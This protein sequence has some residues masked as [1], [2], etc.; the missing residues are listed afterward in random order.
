MRSLSLGTRLALIILAGTLITVGSVLLIAYRELVDDFE[1]LLTEQQQQETRR[2]SGEVNRSL[3]LRLDVL[4]DAAGILTDGKNLHSLEEIATLIG[5]HQLLNALF[6]GG[7]LVLDDQGTAISESS[8]VPNRLGTNYSD[9]AHIMQAIVKRT[10][11]ISRPVMGRTTGVPLIAFVAPIET[12]DG[13]LLGM[14]SGTINLGQTSIIPD[15]VLKDAKS[16]G[17]IFTVIDSNNFLYIEGG[18]ESGAR[19]QSLPAPGVD[20]LIDAALSG[21]SFGRIYNMHGRE[22]IYASSHL[23]RLGWQIVRAV[24]YEWA[25]APANASFLRFFWVSLAIA[26]VIALTSFALSRSAIIKLDRMT[27]RIERMVRNP[28]RA[29]RLVPDGP[30]EVRSL[31]EAF[32]RLMDEQ[33]AIATMK[34]HFVSNVSHELRTPLTSINGALRL[35]DSGAAGELPEQA[36]NMASLALRNG[37]RLQL[38]IS[39]L[40]DFSK[41]SS[42]QMT[43][44]LQPEPLQP[45]IESAVSGNQAM[46][47]EHGIT[48]S[49]TCDPDLVLMV[50]A[51][52]L[53]QILD[54]FISNAIKFSPDQG[55]VLVR[56][57]PGTAGRTRI[58]VQDSGEGVP[59]DFV[60]K[61]FDR[62]AQAEAGT[63][64][65]ARGTGLGLA[66]CR[67]LTILMHGRIG[68]YHDH[69]AHFWVELPMAGQRTEPDHDST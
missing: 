22:M 20:P 16:N 58:I 17:T 31:A 66:I 40:L 23:Q 61:L 8:F 41:L 29:G 57:E 48:L 59:E 44:S 62:F 11:V 38:L 13:D 43:V 9:R 42:G 39:D 47:G 50:D 51:L 5:R 32:N 65:S 37:E 15:W 33:D 30:R 2:I 1:T 6:P 7:I 14:L 21:M 46:A 3:Q 52:R 34:E 10:P 28:S 19:I 54:N 12:D 55:R 53:R 18:A 27:R 36:R 68:Y 45:I 35:I 60:A 24:P 56:V 64:R 25:T 26:I 67:E 49:G 63:T 4:S 69:G